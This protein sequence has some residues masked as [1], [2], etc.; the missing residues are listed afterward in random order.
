MGL[1]N[2]ISINTKYR[3]ENLN[4][5]WYVEMGEFDDICYWRKCWG[6]RDDIVRL[7]HMDGKGGTCNL[8]AEDI[9]AIIRVIEKYITGG[10]AYWDEAGHSIWEFSE[11]KEN[12]LQNVGNLLWLKEELERREAEGIT[13]FAYFYDS[14]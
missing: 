11:I 13:D 9:P 5:P 8:E 7:L 12:L 4:L 1:D 6:I 3:G 10:Q 14:Y 2:G